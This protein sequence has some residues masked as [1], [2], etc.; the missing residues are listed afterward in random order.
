MILF[1]RQVFVEFGLPGAPGRQFCDLR[2]AF[3]ADFSRESTPNKG[4]VE[5]YNL[6]PTSLDLL[7]TPGIVVRVFAGYDVPRLIAQG[8]PVPNG[9]SIERRGP[10]RVAKAEFQDGGRAYQGA[11]VTVNVATPTTL[12]AVLNLVAAQVGLPIGA[13][14]PPS[15]ADVA[16]PHGAQFAGPARDV[17]DRLGRSL[18]ADWFVR[19]GALCF[20]GSGSDTGETMLVIGPGNLVGSPAPKDKGRIEATALLEPSLRPGRLFQVQSERI[21]GVYVA[22]SVR[23]QGDNWATPFYATVTG[24]PFGGGR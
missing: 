7:Q 22:D 3:S 5:V 16:L 9:V 19:D 24:I 12:S 11:R 1:G 18:G 8:N 14:R 10:D 21:N 2:I 15:G 23:F 4:T 17:L 20:V 6:A 13:I